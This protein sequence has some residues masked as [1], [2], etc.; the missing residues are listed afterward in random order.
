MNSA[1]I[2][3]SLQ[4]AEVDAVA[5]KDD[6]LTD[7]PSTPRSILIDWANSQDSWVR[8]LVD[9]VLIT[10][11]PLSTEVVDRIYF[12]FQVE[13]GLFEGTF[14]NVV[15]LT[16]NHG[17]D[18]DEPTLV[19]RKLYDLKGINAL[20]GD[21]PL[22]FDDQ[23]TVLFGQNG[24]GKTGYAR[25]IKRAAGVLNYEDILG[26]EWSD[27][28]SPTPAATFEITLD[29]VAETV[30]WKNE[31]GIGALKRVNVFDAKVA[32]IHVDVDLCYAYMPSELALF[33][34]VTIGLIELQER[35]E[36]DI[37]HL[38]KL[39]G[40]DIGM[41][42]RETSTY[43]LVENLGADSD[44]AALEAHATVSATDTDILERLRVDAAFLITNTVDQQLNAANR[45]SLDLES[46]ALLVARLVDFN[47]DAYETARSA[48]DIARTEVERVRTT[49]FASGELAGS[50]DEE[51]QQFAAAG[52][53]YQRHLGLTDYPHAEE[54]CLYCRQQLTAQA[55]ELL[56]KYRTFLDE[57][58]QRQLVLAKARLD[59]L[60]PKFNA[61]QIG[62][63][64][65]LLTTLT[66]TPAWLAEANKILDDADIVSS[67]CSVRSQISIED[68]HS[69]ATGIYKEVEDSLNNLRRR[70]T[71]LAE[72]STNRAKASSDRQREIFELADRIEF[73]RRLSDYKK[74]VYDARRQ[75]N[76]QKRNGDISTRIRHSLTS[77]SAK[78]SRDLVN[79]NF[80]MLFAEECAALAAPDVAVTFQG[81]SGQVERSKTVAGHRPSAILSEGEQNVLALAD[82]LAE[83]RMNGT[84]APIVFDDPVTSLDYRRLNKVAKRL[85]Q[86]AE[87][88]QVIVL[89]HNIWFASALLGCRRRKNQ[90]VNFFEVRENGA[91]KGVLAPDVEPNMDTPT[92]I[93]KRVNAAIAQAK[94]ADPNSQDSQISRA[95][96]L[97]RSWCEV[98]T[99]Q[100]L[101]A[102][103]TQRY[104]S[105][106][107]MT[108]LDKIKVDRL[109]V[110]IAVIGPAFEKICRFITAH[111]NPIE[112][113]N[114]S[115]TITDLEEDWKVLRD[116]R[117]A[118]IA[119]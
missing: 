12:H 38:V 61:E 53:A 88:H 99:E 91:E 2:S 7:D 36:R 95:Y 96:D 18:R 19:L 97:M 60:L 85:C 20:S 65:I 106:V 110:A 92:D 3:A 93:A 115:P 27:S 49:M 62:H 82:F 107:M 90:R 29:G 113:G 118:Y 71:E 102:S 105:N 34:H 35:V 98:F 86:L 50:A 89:T 66:D 56:G 111:S 75:T 64:R 52:A 10:G 80:K 94:L 58:T 54:V 43:N 108:R 74:M 21:Y 119:D 41:F 78:A 44:I 11:E 70:A 101:L 117:K 67:E 42:H 32:H 73:S 9:Q 1:E 23:M 87:V 40:V 4:D 68:L 116:T 104:R 17:S 31:I 114:V 83:C 30:F 28:E 24:S 25:V 55:V 57:S 46:I 14:E 81:H 47:Q 45:Y 39:E 72:Q 63:V 37:Q 15:P 77:A 26:N 33:T 59:S 109:G 100:E 22:E 16:N 6:Q 51:W 84:G 112:Q 79:K 8:E 69:R 5:V 48:E 103:V 76:L 13:Y